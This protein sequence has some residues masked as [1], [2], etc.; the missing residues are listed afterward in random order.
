M[1]DYGFGV[2]TGVSG[3]ERIYWSFGGIYG[4]KLL[5]QLAFG[6]KELGN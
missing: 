5:F 3:K 6:R 2:Q 1:N 4:G